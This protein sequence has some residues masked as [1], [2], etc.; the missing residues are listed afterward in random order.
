LLNAAVWLGAMLFFTAVIGPGLFGPEVK[1]LVGHAEWIPGAI[2]QILVVRYMIL[3]QWCAGI[4]LAHLVFD[5]LYTGKLFAKSSLIIIVLCLGVSLGGVRLLAPQMQQLHMMKYSSQT[6]PAQKEL[7]ARNFRILHA[8][9][10]ITNLLALCGVLFYYSRL[11]VG[12]QG[13]RSGASARYR[14]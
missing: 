13:A 8:T 4:A 7:A 1:Q 6:T 5:W 3:Q 12:P 10:Q 2:A 14:S 9:S 11:S